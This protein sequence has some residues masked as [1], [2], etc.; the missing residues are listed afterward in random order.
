MK[1]M[2]RCTSRLVS[3]LISLLVTWV[4]DWPISADTQWP[5]SPCWLLFLCQCMCSFLSMGFEVFKC[6]LLTSKVGDL[7]GSSSTS[8][9]AEGQDVLVASLA[10]SQGELW[11]RMQKLAAPRPRT[12]QILS[13]AQT[14]LTAAGATFMAELPPTNGT[15]SNAEANASKVKLLQ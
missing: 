10:F 9:G 14:E 6:N 2:V 12:A 5:S 4:R 13:S 7:Q 1:F 3:V 8:L 11:Q 15:K